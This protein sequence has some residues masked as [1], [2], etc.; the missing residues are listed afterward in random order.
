MIGS[1]GARLQSTQNELQQ[2]VDVE[3]SLRDIVSAE[4]REANAG[5]SSGTLPQTSPQPFPIPVDSVAQFHDM[6][7]R[8]SRETTTMSD[9]RLEAFIAL[10]ET[11][12]EPKRR[13]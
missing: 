4:L 13:T 10:A 12:S 3:C 7:V 2:G 5:S 6:M 9:S 11:R 8:E 1:L